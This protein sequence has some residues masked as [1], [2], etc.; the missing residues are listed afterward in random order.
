V[1]IEC[2]KIAA[3]RPGIDDLVPHRVG[4]AAYKEFGYEE[5]CHKHHQGGPQGDDNHEYPVSEPKHEK[6]Q[7]NQCYWHNT[8]VP[9]TMIEDTFIALEKGPP[10][11][12]KLVSFPELTIA[13][14][15]FTME[16][17]RM[18]VV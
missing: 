9:G 16:R 8:V 1:E 12:T 15:T 5:M 17:P 11:I 18:M 13:V 3:N 10:F 14:D 2:R 4:K 6:T 7:L